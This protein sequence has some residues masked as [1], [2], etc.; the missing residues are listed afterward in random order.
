MGAY[1]GGDALGE[2]GSEGSVDKDESVEVAHVLSDCQRGN[3]VK[4]AEGVA[5]FQEFLHI[6]LVQSPRH[7]QHNIVDHVTISTRREKREEKR[8][9][10]TYDRREREGE[11][12]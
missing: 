8:F 4:H 3:A 1:L 7:N 2:V 5:L 9:M 12:G 10:N 6:S 11:R